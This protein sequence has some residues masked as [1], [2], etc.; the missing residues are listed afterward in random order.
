[1]TP[2]KLEI[3]KDDNKGSKSLNQ[4]RS[5]SS[6]V[7]KAA[8]QVQSMRGNVLNNNDTFNQ[9]HEVLEKTHDSDGA[10]EAAIKVNNI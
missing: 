5:F 7:V 3:E 10:A 2:K 9:I 8:K 6:Q 4:L 1:M